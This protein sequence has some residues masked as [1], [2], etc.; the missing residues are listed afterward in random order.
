MVLD[1]RRI[2]VREI[3]DDV[4]ISTTIFTDVLGMKRAAVKIAKFLAKTT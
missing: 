4:G 1:N 3:V 2:I